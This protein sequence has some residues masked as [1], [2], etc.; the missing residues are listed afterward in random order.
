[1]RK[2]IRENS[3]T[4][5]NILG[6]IIPGLVVLG[7]ILMIVFLFIIPI[8]QT[9][10][11]AIA[12]TSQAQASVTEVKMLGDKYQI[13]YSFLANR[14]KWKGETKTSISLAYNSDGGFK[15]FPIWYEAEN[16]S[17]SSESQAVEGGVWF[18]RFIFYGLVVFLIGVY[19]AYL[20]SLWGWFK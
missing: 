15:K 1:M 7:V 5:E 17:N 16:P 13:T 19:F 2:W 6:T 11:L 12:R 14:S 10:N 8:E 9:N 20:N 18:V 4:W 3:K